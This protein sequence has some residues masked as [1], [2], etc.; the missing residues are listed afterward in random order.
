MASTVAI[1]Q[2]TTI[3]VD[4]IRS[5]VDKVFD[6]LKQKYTL[7]GEWK[8]DKLFVI[9]G[10]QIIGRLEIVGRSVEVTITL[11]W[12]LSAFSKMIESQVQETLRNHLAP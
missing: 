5:S 11:G 10:E 8:N 1:S 4:R 7:V 6:E 12:M 9:S 2:P 3:P